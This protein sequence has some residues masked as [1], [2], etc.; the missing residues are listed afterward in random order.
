MRKHLL[1]RR[2]WQ[3]NLPP[4]KQL[5]QK[6]RFWNVSGVH[7]PRFSCLARGESWSKSRRRGAMSGPDLMASAWVSASLLGSWVLTLVWA[8]ESP[9]GGGWK[10]SVPGSVSTWKVLSP[11]WLFAT[12]WTIQ[13]LEFSRPEY[14]SEERFHSQGDLPNLGM[15]PRSPALQADSLPAEPQGM[16]NNTGVGSLSLPQRI[17]LT[18]ESNRGL[19][20]CRQILYQLSHRGSL[21]ILW[22]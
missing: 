12:P 19:P 17:F 21:R 1:N 3:R 7:I 10:S 18:Q 11:V 20:H 14:W 9:G 4:L 22:A 15:E 13:S 2:A 6:S 5:L 8:L 16:P